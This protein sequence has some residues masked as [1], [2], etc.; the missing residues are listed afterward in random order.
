MDA[1][2]NIK[3]DLSSVIKKALKCKIIQNPRIGGK[4]FD[5]K[6]LISSKYSYFRDE[7]DYKNSLPRKYEDD[8]YLFTMIEDSG[9]FQANYEFERPAKRKCHLKK[10]NLCYLPPV[11]DGVVLK[12]YIRIDYHDDNIGFFHSNVHM[13]V[14]FLSRIRIPLDEVLLFSEFFNF[15]LYFHY[16]DSFKRFNKEMPITHTFSTG[17]PRMTRNVV[18]SN[19]LKNFVYLQTQNRH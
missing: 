7:E 13:H 17:S 1:F 6:N 15:I 18:L 14:G 8:E 9:L 3:E 10:M 5:N 16:P 11:E 2:K 12:D 4:F 19:E